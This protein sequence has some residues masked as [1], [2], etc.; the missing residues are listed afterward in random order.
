[1]A[2]AA[3]ARGRQRGGRAGSQPNATGRTGPGW[4]AERPD[5]GRPRAQIPFAPEPDADV[6]PDMLDRDARAELRSLP[7]TLAD[8][9]AKHLVMA[10]RLLEED[11]DVAY[12][13]AAKAQALASRVAVAREAL[14]LA[15]Y[16]TGKWAQALS[17]LRAARRMSGLGRPPAGDGRL[18][19]GPGPARTSP[20]P[21]RHARGRATRPRRPDRDAHR[22]LRR[23]PRP[24]SARRR[25]RDPSAPRAEVIEGCQPWTGRLRYA[26]ADA[27][28]AAGRE[29]EA[30]DWFAEAVDADPDG[31]TDAAERLEE[32]DGTV[33][34]DLLPEDE[35]EDRV[36]RPA[37]RRAVRRSRRSADD[38]VERLDAV[39]PAHDA[40]EVRPVGVEVLVA[41]DPFR[42][43]EE[44]GVADSSALAHAGEGVVEV[45]PVEPSA[46]DELDP[47]A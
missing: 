46:T 6:T 24:R 44:V 21:R 8:D 38:R 30:R 25:R 17:E 20:R 13:H 26:Y 31:L 41:R 42:V 35:S 19:A 32:L 15:A 40:D 7:A 34:I 28:L 12:Q 29:D 18:R 9:V 3:P 16:A 11:P 1:M 36:G 5:D 22:R 27:L 2:S 33:Y 47:Q 39:Q 14:G 23:T 4:R 43:A 45:E 37:G 10:G